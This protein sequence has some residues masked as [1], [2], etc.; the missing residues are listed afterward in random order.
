MQ[1]IRCDGSSSKI[2][3]NYRIPL[4]EYLFFQQIL[5]E[6]EF[7]VKILTIVAVINQLIPF[8]DFIWDDRF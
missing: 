6:C 2:R 3:I 7:V 4:L 5:V 8:N 1:S